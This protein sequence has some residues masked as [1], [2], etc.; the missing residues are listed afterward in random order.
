MPKAITQFIRRSL[1]L[2]LISSSL[3]LSGCGFHLRGKVLVPLNMRTIHITGDDAELIAEISKSLRFSDI[4]IAASREGVA[5]LDLSDTVYDRTVNSTSSAGQ[6][7]SYELE[8]KVNYIVLDPAGETTQEQRILATRTFNFDNTQ[9]LV[10]ER[11]EGFLKKDMQKEVTS[12]LLRRLS[13][14]N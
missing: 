14:I 12:K 3:V 11:E 7:T 9:I 2:T 8:Y 13:K 6:A 1:L 4:H 5:I 10:S